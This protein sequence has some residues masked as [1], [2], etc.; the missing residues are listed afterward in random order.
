M[1]EDGR[2]SELLREAIPRMRAQLEDWGIWSAKDEEAAW[3]EARQ[4]LAAAVQ[5]VEKGPALTADT[6][7]TDVYAQMP[8]NLIDQKAEL[9]KELEERGG[10]GHG[11]GAFPL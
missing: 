4:E 5:A 11:E 10:T 6:L 2:A 1:G 9:D 3:A 7:F 8:P